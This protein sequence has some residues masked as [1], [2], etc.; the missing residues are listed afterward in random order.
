M[1]EV[2]QLTPD[3]D[4]AIRAASHL[5]RVSFGGSDEGAVHYRREVETCQV[6]AVL[7]GGQVSGVATLRPY[8]QWFAG[9]ELAMAGL[10]GVAVAAQA[11]RRGVAGTLL[12]AAL[13]R[14]HADGTPVS[15]LYA[16]SPPV[17]RASGWESAGV[18]TSVELP[19]V[20]LPSGAPGEVALRALDRQAP[21]DA[22][23]ASVHTLYTAAART[24]VGPLTRTGPLFDLTKLATLDAVV[25]ASVD[26]VDAGYVSWSRRHDRLDVHDLIADRPIV[27]DTLLG[28]VGSWQTTIATARVRWGDPV[29]GAF[30]LPRYAVL[31]QEAWMLRIVDAAAAVA[32]RGFGPV[33][34]AVDL[35]LTD[36]KAPWQEGRWRLEVAAGAATLTRGGCGA[37]GLNA[38]GLAALFTGYA[39]ADTLARAGLAGGEPAAL[40]LLSA[41]FA[42]PTPWMLDE[43]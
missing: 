16:S 2:V 12:A 9:R 22:D 38:R 35:V 10:G 1:R 25:I 3:D 7:D 15:T 33:S 34:G 42:G 26:G 29:L 37:V 8:R 27:R 4:A 31:N 41:L 17:Y 23:L 21:A 20:G 11:R 6:L 14:M 43:F 5:V 18:L 19:T 32:G 39:G 40:G 13:D 28:A 30:G 36:P 24:A